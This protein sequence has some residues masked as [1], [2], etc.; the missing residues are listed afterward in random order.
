MVGAGDDGLA[1]VATFRGHF[2]AIRAATF[3]RGHLV[4]AAV[5]QSTQR[6]RRSAATLGFGVEPLRGKPQY[7]GWGWGAEGELRYDTLLVGGDNP[8][9]RRRSMTGG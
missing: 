8:D 1:P 2:V 9:A 6:A 7:G 5:P 3:L 4:G